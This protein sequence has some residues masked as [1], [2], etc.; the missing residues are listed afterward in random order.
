V[1][2]V[3]VRTVVCALP[4][5]TELRSCAC[6]AAG[7][8]VL[9][10]NCMERETQVVSIAPVARRVKRFRR[11]QFFTVAY[12]SATATDTSGDL[13]CAGGNLSIHSTPSAASPF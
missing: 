3:V 10:G 13:S 4:R 8:Q 12:A 9:D 2:R 11:D 1:L 7:P 6:A 5:F